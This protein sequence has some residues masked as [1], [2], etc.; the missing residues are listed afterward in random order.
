MNVW[1][2][3]LC[4]SSRINVNWRGKC[5]KTF[6][7]V[8]NNSDHDNWVIFTVWMDDIY[9]IHTYIEKKRK[10]K[11]TC[12]ITDNTVFQYTTFLTRRL[13]V[14]EAFENLGYW[15]LWQGKW[16]PFNIF[17]ILGQLYR[18]FIHFTFIS[19]LIFSPDYGNVRSFR[20]NLFTL[21]SSWKGT[22]FST[23]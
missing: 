1:A 3:V 14:P 17:Y 15:I 22:N 20:I 18:F 4:S 13:L 7:T 2:Y 19:L 9:K 21:F 5:I 16:R 8:R 12:S 6:C 23:A 10:Q 11:K